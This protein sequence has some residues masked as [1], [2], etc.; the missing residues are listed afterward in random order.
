MKV[1]SSVTNK[2]EEVNDISASSK[3]KMNSLPSELFETVFSD[4]DDTALSRMSTLNNFFNLS[5]L[6]YVK[7]REILKIKN[8]V[9]FINENINNIVYE[10]IVDQL[11]SI[12]DESEILNCTNLK[13]IRQLNLQSKTCIVDLMR[14]LEKND[15][16]RLIDLLDERKMP[17]FFVDFFELVSRPKSY[18]DQLQFLQSDED[19]AELDASIARLNPH[20]HSVGDMFIPQLEFH[21]NTF[22]FQNN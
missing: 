6:D 15:L 2:F 8:L 11:N 19:Q 18:A 12:I 5:V 17:S 16:G 3:G 10:K 4:L 7:Q 14:K 13:Q 1:I 9:K 21:F 22:G 20:N